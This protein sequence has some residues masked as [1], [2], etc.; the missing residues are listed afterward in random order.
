MGHDTSCKSKK[1]LMVG[2][3]VDSDS[4]MVDDGAEWQPTIAGR[5]VARLMIA[6]ARPGHECSCATPIPC[7]SGPS[8]ALKILTPHFSL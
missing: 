4:K 6:Q 5:P 8:W 2:V 3:E 7:V 1:N